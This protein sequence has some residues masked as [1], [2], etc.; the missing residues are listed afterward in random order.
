[1]GDLQAILLAAGRG[2]RLY[3]FTSHCPK[4]LMPIQGKPL[5]EYWLCM[6]KRANFQRVLVNTHAHKS[7]VRSYLDQDKFA[8]WVSAAPETELL[9]TA[10][11]IRANHEWLRGRAFL[12]AHADNWCHADIDDF[13]QFHVEKRPPESV[14][15][16]MTFDSPRPESCGIVLTDEDGVVQEFFE[17]VKEPPGKRANGAVYL[18]EPEVSEWIKENRAVSDFSEQVLPHFLGRIATWHN[19][20]I[21]RDIGTPTSLLSAQSDPP[22][23]SCW[24]Y[25]G[26]WADN[27]AQ[28]PVHEMIRHRQ[29]EIFE[30][31]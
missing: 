25:F 21:H 17:K 8:T 28:N 10:G 2:T 14:I 18:V 4:C 20:A 7:L 27:F 29:E 22:P 12:M 3:P 5:L 16:M 6:L 13:V 1:M 24:P 26:E 30:D 31:G 15:T 11:T 19:N 9:G 23:Q